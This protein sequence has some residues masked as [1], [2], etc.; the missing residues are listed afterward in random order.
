MATQGLLGLDTIRPAMN[1]LDARVSKID[2]TDPYLQ[3]YFNLMNNYG[4]GAG[5][6]IDPNAVRQTSEFVPAVYDIPEF[7][8]G[9]FNP[10]ENTVVEEV[11]QPAVLEGQA[12]WI[13]PDYTDPGLAPVEE[14]I[15]RTP[16]QILADTPTKSIS[17]APVTTGALPPG[18]IDAG[19]TTK[20]VT[21]SVTMNIIDPEGTETTQTAVGEPVQLPVSDA[22]EDIYSGGGEG[23]D[24]SAV[25]A[26]GPT[27]TA[28]QKAATSGTLPVGYRQVYLSDEPATRT[29]TP[30]VGMIVTDPYGVQ[31]S[32]ESV[33][34]PITLGQLADGISTDVEGYIP[35]I[36]ESVLQRPDITGDIDLSSIDVSP[37]GLLG[38]ASI[39]EETEDLTPNSRGDYSTRVGGVGAQDITGAQTG[40]VDLGA[41]LADAMPEIMATIPWDYSG[42]PTS[43]LI[44]EALRGVL[45]PKMGLGR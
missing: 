43:D 2:E 22:G 45:R 11:V 15:A 26:M 16:E 30:S 44:A 39:L 13:A 40:E 27:K 42:L 36:P 28:W 3:R 18:L 34:S 24:S 7:R 23:L 6:F 5:R 4:Y 12:S 41:Y 1:L 9:R 19:E 38:S 29:V 20:T 14:A 32:T 8:P 25:E 10:I 17:T 35:T 21:P 33:G 31:T 37:E